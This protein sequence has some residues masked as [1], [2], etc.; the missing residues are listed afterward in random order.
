MLNNDKVAELRYGLLPGAVKVYR[1]NP[2]GSKGGLLRTEKP[3]ELSYPEYNPRS[4]KRRK[5]NET[6]ETSQA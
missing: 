5:R 4:Y 2:D 6:A 1:M 3:G